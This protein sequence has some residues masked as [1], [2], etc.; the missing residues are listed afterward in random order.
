MAMCC[1]HTSCPDSAGRGLH[2]YKQGLSQ[3]CPYIPSRNQRINDMIPL[4]PGHSTFTMEQ[5][6][7]GGVPNLQGCSVL[8]LTALYNLLRFTQ[9]WDSAHGRCLQSLRYMNA[10]RQ[11][12]AT[13]L[14]RA[15]SPICFCRHFSTA[16]LWLAGYPKIQ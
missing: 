7:G 6:L 3:A 4:R 11:A 8:F 2:T 16:R 1:S 15:Q 12:S 14:H 10:V 13:Q 5:E 9:H